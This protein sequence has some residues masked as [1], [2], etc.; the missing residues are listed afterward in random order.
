MGNISRL[1]WRTAFVLWRSSTMQLVLECQLRLVEQWS[2]GGGVKPQGWQGAGAELDTSDKATPSDYGWCSNRGNARTDGHRC[3]SGFAPI[4]ELVAIVD[5]WEMLMSHQ[6]Q[7]WACPR[8]AYTAPASDHCNSCS[9][10][11]WNQLVVDNKSLFQGRIDCWVDQWAHRL[12]ISWGRSPN[13]YYGFLH[14]YH[15]F[16]C[17]NLLT[18]GSWWG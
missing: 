12:W 17:I 6:I 14:W 11:G 4:H 15:A 5:F 10:S 1:H 3:R 9:N 18:Y 16:C 7:E 2:D 13:C 8:S